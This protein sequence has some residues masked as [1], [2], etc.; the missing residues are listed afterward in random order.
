ML[1]SSSNQRLRRGPPAN[2]H[3]R[4][5]RLN[6][7]ESTDPTHPITEAEINVQGCG[8]CRGVMTSRFVRLWRVEIESGCV[9]SS[10]T[11]HGSFASIWRSFPGS[12]STR[13]STRRMAISPKL[14]ITAAIDCCQPR[15][16]Q[17]RSVYICKSLAE[18]TDVRRIRSRTRGSKHEDD[19]LVM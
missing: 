15:A 17:I 18:R 12:R 3:L 4:S 11:H 8:C 19:D 1:D 14:E 13:W 6:S 9:D 7:N 2:I 5:H 16:I 10:T